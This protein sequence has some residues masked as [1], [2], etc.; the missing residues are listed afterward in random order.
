VICQNQ[1]R[2]QEVDEFLIELADL[3][4]VSRIEESAYAFP[5][6]PGNLRD[7]LAAGHLFPGL[8]LNHTL[9]AYS[10]LMPVLDE[11]HLLNITVAPEFQGQGW[12]KEMLLISMRLASS[13]LKGQSMLLEVRPSNT[14]ALSMYEAHGFKSIGIRKQYYP[15]AEGREDAII[16]RRALP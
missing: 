8:K 7:S 15:A 3:E 2:L 1:D 13:V 10:I 11:T 16:L 9:I 14:I 6:T 12:G 4:A 5:W